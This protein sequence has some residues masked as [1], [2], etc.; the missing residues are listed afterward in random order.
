M[1]TSALFIFVLFEVN[2][3]APFSQFFF[4]LKTFKASIIST[5]QRKS[6]SLHA[7][8][9]QKEQLRNFYF[10]NTTETTSCKNYYHGP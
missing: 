3:L 8:I 1:L 5:Y 4:F 2:S 9:G 10:L 6:F 7:C